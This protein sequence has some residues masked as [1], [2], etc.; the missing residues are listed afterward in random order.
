MSSTSGFCLDK[1]CWRIYEQR[2]HN[3][4]KQG[5]GDRAKSIRVVWRNTNQDWQVES[6]RF[7]Q[8]TNS[9]SHYSQNRHVILTI[10][11]VFQTGLVSS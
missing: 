8:I 5:L 6:V 9:T 7:F 2:V 10:L 11:T 3:L 4:L 1:E